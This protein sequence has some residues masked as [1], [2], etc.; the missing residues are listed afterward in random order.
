ME[1]RLTMDVETRHVMLELDRAYWYVR[2]ARAHVVEAWN[3]AEESGMFKTERRCQRM[4]ALLDDL[5]ARVIAE[6]DRI[7]EAYRDE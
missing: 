6:C 1:G 4:A 2:E 5:T 3:T 7:E